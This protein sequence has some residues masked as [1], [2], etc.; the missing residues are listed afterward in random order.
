ML[1]FGE[2]GSLG[3]MCHTYFGSYRHP[4]IGDKYSVHLYEGNPNL[5]SL[6]ELHCE[7]VFWQDP[8]NIDILYLCLK[9]PWDVQLACY[10]LFTRCCWFRFFVCVFVLELRVKKKHPT[11]FCLSQIR[12][13]VALLFVV[14]FS[15]LRCASPLLTVF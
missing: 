5:I 3:N 6:H 9:N 4:T 12:S 10:V 8:I 13:V 7:P 15:Y 2:P 14:F 1:S 11:F